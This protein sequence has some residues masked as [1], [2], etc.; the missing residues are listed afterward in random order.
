MRFNTSII[1]VGHYVPSMKLTNADM[2]QMADTNNKWIVDNLGIKERRISRTLPSDMA[3]IAST[4]AMHRADV[5]ATDIDMIIVGTTMGD[6]IAP[7]TACII[8][9]RLG[10]TNSVAF[11]INA[12]CS[13]YL[14]AQDMAL[15]YKDIYK[16]MLI[17]GV[18]QFSTIIDFSRRDCVF[19]GD[20]AGAA[21]LSNGLTEG[22]FINSIIDSDSEDYLAFY[23]NHGETF[24]MRGRGVYDRA[25]VLVPGIIERVLR[26]A[27]I[28]TEDVN[29]VIPHQ[30]STNIL[31]EVSKRTGIP[32]DKFL[33]NMDKYANTAAAS[34]PLLLSESWGKFKRGDIILF[35]SIGSGWTYGAAIYRV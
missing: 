21:I 16:T 20:G 4:I 32:Y 35:V 31:K 26:E 28:K 8:R 3:V 7:P 27:R 30:P 33:I 10:A 9:E 2:E 34:I 17:V 11:D 12:V 18:D 15:R 13:S 29:Y 6:K 1:G 24:N 23:C 14:F 19:F 22:G 5:E 25:V